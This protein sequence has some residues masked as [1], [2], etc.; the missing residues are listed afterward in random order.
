MGIVTSEF[1]DLESLT[2]DKGLVPSG[3]KVTCLDN[4]IS[5][6]SSSSLAGRESDS[7]ASCSKGSCV[8]LGKYFLELSFMS[9]FILNVG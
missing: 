4:Q 6:K 5:P 7:I 1:T 3:L 2:Y 9:G 8:T